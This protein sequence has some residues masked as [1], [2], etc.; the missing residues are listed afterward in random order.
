MLCELL[1]FKLALFETVNF[2][3]ESQEDSS[4]TDGIKVKWFS[5]YSYIVDI[6]IKTSLAWLK[7]NFFQIIFT[8]CLILCSVTAHASRLGG[9]GNM[10]G[11]ITKYSGLTPR[12]ILMIKRI[13][14]AKKKLHY[15]RFAWKF[16][17]ESL[18]IHSSDMHRIVNS[19]LIS[20]V[21]F[22]FL[23]FIEG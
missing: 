2:P 15:G 19:K 6:E 21:N 4:V 22:I 23:D 8:V 9:K 13:I 12:Q 17:I 10:R 18:D 14:Q 1:S 3:L 20:F 11:T 5:H 16:P 7:M